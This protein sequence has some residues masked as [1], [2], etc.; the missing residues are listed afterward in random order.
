MSWNYRVVT[1]D[2]GTTYGIH[3]VYY[4]NDSSVYAWSEQSIR[5]G[6]ENIE[7]VFSDLQYMLHAFDLPVLEETEEG[8]LREFQKPETR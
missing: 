1:Q 3:E 2:K 7:D 6:G 8:T 5:P 4:R